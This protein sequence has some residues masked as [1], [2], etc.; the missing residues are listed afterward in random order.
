MLFAHAPD[1]QRDRQRRLV[2]FEL[3]QQVDHGRWDR[4]RAAEVGPLFGYQGIEA[5]AAVSAQPAA[6]GL[7]GHSAAQRAR[8]VVLALSLLCEELVQAAMLKWK[9]CQVGDHAVA[10]QRDGLVRRVDVGPAVNDIGVE[11]IGSHA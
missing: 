11:R 5:A 7:C 4:A 2:I 1:E 6:D 9:L 10:K 8:D 3:A